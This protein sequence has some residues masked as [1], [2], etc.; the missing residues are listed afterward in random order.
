MA[1]ATPPNGVR[2]PNGQPVKGKRNIVPAIPLHYPNHRRGPSKA[3]VS[4]ETTTPAKSEKSDAGSGDERLA[5]HS[6]GVQHPMTPESLSS[7]VH[8]VEAGNDSRE[9][10]SPLSG[11]TSEDAKVVNGEL[12]VF[13]CTCTW[14]QTDASCRSRS[15]RRVHAST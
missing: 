9:G 5:S 1:S 6:D 10:A 12:K 13:F 8:K 7:S 2:S 15:Q 4:Q 3:A 14:H 11:K